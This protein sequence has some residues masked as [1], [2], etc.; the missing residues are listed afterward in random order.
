MKMTRE[1]SITKHR[2]ND[3]DPDL[4]ATVVKTPQVETTGQKNGTQSTKNAVTTNDMEE[5]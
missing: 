1:R 3:L 5:Q 2:S 4:V